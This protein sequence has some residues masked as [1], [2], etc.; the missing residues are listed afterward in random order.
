MTV[1]YLKKCLDE[2]KA[3][4]LVKAYQEPCCDGDGKFSSEFSDVR[5]THELNTHGIP[6]RSLTAKAPEKLPG[7]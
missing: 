3:Q 4:E 2:K 1:E 5:Y 7:T 6:Y